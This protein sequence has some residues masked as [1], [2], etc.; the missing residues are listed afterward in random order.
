[1]SLDGYW[2]QEHNV[3]LYWV[4]ETDIFQSRRWPKY[5]ILV[6]D[7]YPKFELIQ[8]KEKYGEAAIKKY[9]TLST[10]PWI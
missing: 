6:K 7:T 10:D 3:L 9:K 1:M 2:I 8:P 4:F 5:T